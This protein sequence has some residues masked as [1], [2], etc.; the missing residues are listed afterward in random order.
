V[1]RTD[2]IVVGAGVVGLAIARALA[3]Q[4]R[5][6]IVLEAD[7]AI[8]TGASSRNSEVVH[9]GLYY[10]KDSLKARFCVSGRERLYEYAADRGISAQAIG[11]L[12]VA[13]SPAEVSTLYAIEQQGLGNGVIDLRILTREEARRL[14]PEVECEAALYSPSSGI[15]DSHALMLSL[16][17]DLENAGG[18]IAFKSP[19]LG[20]DIRP[21]ETIVR[22]G[23]A[24]PIEMQCNLLVNAAG[25]YASELAQS[26]KGLLPKHV[27]SPYYC[28][29]TYYSLVGAKSPFHHLIYP[30]PNKAGLGIHA[31]I[32]LGGQIRFGPDTVW[33]EQPDFSPDP[34]NRGAFEVAIRRYWPSL[35]A[36]AL[37][38]T[39]AGVRAKIVGPGQEPADFR[40]DG[41]ET[42]GLTS[43]INLF[44]IESPGL[45]ASLAI[46]D[47]VASLE[48]S[49]TRKVN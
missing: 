44:G 24:A 2:V 22:V 4:G 26:F 23:G 47:H 27:P 19:L 42:H 38:A 7:I 5:E 29:G 10:P 12:V 30:T 49:R 43:L 39:Y 34:V 41:P 37:E 48:Q 21:S 46:A 9:A 1:D 33:I 45:T 31:T 35:P 20:A 14:E 32:D 16:Q 6:V 8:G 25:L 18:V 17:G 15:V 13:S 11:K 40:I 28:K 3:G 36:N